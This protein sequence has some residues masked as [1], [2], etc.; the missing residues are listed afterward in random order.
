MGREKGGQQEE[1]KREEGTNDVYTH[2]GRH[3]EPL[4]EK[5]AHTWLLITHERPTHTSLLRCL[6]LEKTKEKT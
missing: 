3:P 6:T 2:T 5:H 4:R 1:E